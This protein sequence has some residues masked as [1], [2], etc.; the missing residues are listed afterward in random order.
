[1]KLNESKLREMI[2]EI[3]NEM[4]QE[5]IAQAKQTLIA[6]SNKL[7][8]LQFSFSG[9]SREKIANAQREIESVI[10]GV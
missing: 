4:S 2:S 10:T 9:K 6:M 8:E 3:I 1:M 5:K 7:S